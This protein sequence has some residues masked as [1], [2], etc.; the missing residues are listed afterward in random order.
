MFTFNKKPIMLI[1]AGISLGVLFIYLGTSLLARLRVEAPVRLYR[2]LAGFVTI[3]GFVMIPASIVCGVTVMRMHGCPGGACAP[4]EMR[5]H[6][7]GPGMHDRQH[8][9]SHHE[10]KGHGP[11]GA[12]CGQGDDKASCCAGKDMKEC[13]SEDKGK[14]AEGKP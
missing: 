12:C 4:H 13:C 14:E 1:L 11:M 3:M 8:A 2:N 9:C 7:G 10:G 5:G 6:M